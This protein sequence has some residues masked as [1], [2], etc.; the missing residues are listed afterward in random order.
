MTG[1]DRSVGS[2]DAHAVAL[3]AARTSASSELVFAAMEATRTAMVVSD[4]RLPDNPI[5]FANRAFRDLSGYAHEELIGRNCRFLQ[6]PGTDPADVARIREAVAAGRE[7]TCDL[8]N[9]RRDGSGF[10]NELHISPIFDDA[11]ELRYFF[12]SQTDLA[13]YRDGTKRLQASEERYRSLFDALDAGFCT[14]EMIYDEAGRP[15]DYRFLE[16]NPAFATQT[17][18]AD[19][20]GRTIRELA[21]AH[22]AR[23]FEIYG[24]VDHDRRPL[25]FEDEAKALGRW[26]EVHAFPVG[27][28]GQHRLAALFTDI[29]GRRRAEQDLQALNATLESQVTERTRELEEAGEA[30]R[31]SQ[32]LEAIGQLT[33]GVAHDF[34][35][36][37]TIIRSA[38]EFLKRPNL[39]EPRRARYVEA[40]AETS[41]RAAALTGQ[42]LAFARRQPLKPEVFDV[43]GRIEGVA[44]LARSL[45]GSQIEV[46]VEHRSEDGCRTLAD[47]NQL[48]AAL[49]NLASNARDAMAGVGALSFV[50][51]RAEGLPAIRD[52]P[53]RE[54]RFIA[55]DV[56][57]T[58][59]RASMR[60]ACRGFSSRSSR[61]RRS[62][63]ARGSAS[64]RCSASPSSPGGTWTCALRAREQSSPCTC[65]PPSRAMPSARWRRSSGPCCPATPACSWWRT[66]RRSAASPPSSCT[67][68]G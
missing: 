56:R 3:S 16:T 26:Y 61:P 46:S 19:A 30:L 44:E 33:G 66:T 7:I 1:S 64:A 21:P 38:A 43:C 45:V 18:L 31:Q 39:T 37:L 4:P 9:Y 55:V 28:P 20:V 15:V 29:T 53:A 23:W 59:G 24:R 54:G 17:G 49:L 67:M 34:N 60:R 5:V 6:G 8:L 42:L 14:F 63:R 36:L 52:H 22:E 48:D 11:G 57:D 32:K 58:R 27:E 2:R 50:T 41:E 62:A 40:I 47:A 51:R 68:S 65:P 12:G 25:R 35:N 10:I 13:R